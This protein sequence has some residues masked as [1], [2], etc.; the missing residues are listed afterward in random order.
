MYVA[1]YRILNILFQHHAAHMTFLDGLGSLPQLSAY[2]RDALQRL[3]DDALSK[4]LDL[5]PVDNRD[6]LF[7]SVPV[8]N[9]ATSIQFGSFA[10]PKGPGNTAI[11]SFNLQ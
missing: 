9:P 4:L 2:S 7:A 6:A 1:L 11:H 8:Y 3:K 5:V 10:I